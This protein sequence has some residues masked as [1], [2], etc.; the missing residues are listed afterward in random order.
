MS[1]GGPPL[2]AAE[3]D[4]RVRGWFP[5][6]AGTR[7]RRVAWPAVEP[8]REFICEQLKA[9][10]TVATIRQ[11]LRD[12]RG[13]AVSV[14]GL[15]RYVAA[16]VPEGTRRSQVRV[17]GRWPAGPGAEAQVDYGRLGRWLG[18]AAG[19]LVTVW[20]FVMVLSCSRYMFVRPV[21]W[22]GQQAWSECQVK[23]LAFF[24]AVAARL[25]PGSLK[26]GVDRPGLYDPKIN[27]SYAGL[28]AHYG[29]LPDPA[30]A[31]RP[32]GKPRAGRPMAY[33]RDSF[34]RGRQFASLGQVQAGAERWCARVAGMRA[35][36]RLDGAA[37]A[38]VFAAAGKD[39]LSPLP[40]GPFVLAAWAK[41]K[42]GPDI[43]ARVGK[44][45]YSVPWRH[46]GTTAGVRVTD[47][48][49][50]LF[51]GGDLVKTHPRQELGQAGRL[52]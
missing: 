10:V 4:A 43:H 45:V 34:W 15:R 17:L 25:V 49:V 20:A 38:A 40:A 52:R 9:G 14:A 3:W 31:F 24:G 7:L 18:R 29:F 39:A 1:R 50:Q 41:A 42:I 46:T 2:S 8:H 13:V 23:A 32:A 5:E 19:K 27:R 11:R 51:I 30:R 36:R 33:V 26:T 22:L 47:T 35:C 21:I 44:V 6:L 48:M 37:P 28:A 16:S 12:E